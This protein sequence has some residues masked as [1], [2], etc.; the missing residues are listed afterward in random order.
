MA[1]DD[2]DFD[3][4]RIPSQDPSRRKFT[5][6]EDEQLLYLVQK[7]GTKCWEALS[8]SMVNRSGRQCRDR[9]KNYLAGNFN[10]GPWIQEE[11]E[12]IYKQYFEI[13][14][15]WV[16]ISKILNNRSANDV[17]NRWHKVLSKDHTRITKYVHALAKEESIPKPPERKVEVRIY[18]KIPKIAQKAS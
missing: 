1:L 15:K 10:K 5:K 6:E 11:D 2:E 3:L 14:P 7:Y 16:E 8:R 17:K 4:S 18:A 12:I 9:Y 13:G